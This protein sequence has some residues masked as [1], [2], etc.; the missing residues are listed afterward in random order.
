MRQR[1]REVLGETPGLKGRQIA[2]KIGAEKS[3]VNSFL[4]KN[5]DHFFQDSDYCW[6]VVNAAEL[7][8]GLEADTWVDGAS[9]DSSIKSA[10]M[11]LEGGHGKVVFIVPKDCRIFLEAAARLLALSNQLIFNGKEVTIDFS[12]CKA[13]L[14]YFDRIGFLR[15]LDPKVVVTPYRPKVSRADTYKGNSDAVVEFGKIDPIALDEDIP[16]HLK[17]SFV[18][19]AG[20]DYSQ[21]AF[22]VISE[23]YGNVGDHSE[24]PIPG[25]A[26]LQYYKGYKGYNGKPPHIQTVVSDSGKGIVGTLKPI[27]SERYPN[28][29]S[30]FDFS[31]PEAEVLLVKEVFDHGHITQSDDEGRGLGLKRSSDVAAKYNATISVRQENFELKL[32]YKNGELDDFSYV[33]ELPTIRGT[34]VCFDFILDSI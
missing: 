27:L 20:E 15:H 5:R 29:A 4:S 3:E 28:L 26:A 33:L 11:P 17:N 14:S 1:I 8:I 10:G 21:P 9:L 13:T 23:L 18:A 6:F 30:K 7:E 16:M 12:D 19:H 24:A 22:T 2:R 25:F 34:H 31:D 32:L